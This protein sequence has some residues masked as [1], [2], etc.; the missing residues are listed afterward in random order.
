[1]VFI[2]ALLDVKDPEENDLI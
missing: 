1:V 2:S